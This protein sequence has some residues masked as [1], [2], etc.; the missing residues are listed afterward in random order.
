MYPHSIAM[1]QAPPTPPSSFSGLA[2]AVQ[3]EKLQ[4]TLDAYNVQRIDVELKELEKKMAELKDRKT[5]LMGHRSKVTVTA[6]EATAK[7]T[8][9]KAYAEGFQAG[10][11][12]GQAGTSSNQTE[13]RSGKARG[14]GPRQRN[15]Q[16]TD[17]FELDTA[18]TIGIDPRDPR[19]HGKGPCGME[20]RG[21][22]KK[23]Q[24]ALWTQCS[25]CCLR[26]EYTPFTHASAQSSRIENPTDVCTALDELLAADVW[27]NMEAKQ[28]QAKIK[29]ITAR[30][31]NHPVK[32]QGK[33]KGKSTQ[34]TMNS[35]GEME[36]LME[37]PMNDYSE[38]DWSDVH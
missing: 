9:E 31:H 23:N 21:T 20:H 32:G 8:A 28:M 38:E 6:A 37:G 17:S 33:G 5:Q 7:T 29:E 25:R 1:A 14:K 26:L 16:V 3:M 24:W 11:R 2:L 27:D 35:D 4:Q 36:H 30:K 15:E 18:R 34:F 13:T 22:L 19:A 10:S 12:S